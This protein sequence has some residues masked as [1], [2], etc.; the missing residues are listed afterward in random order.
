MRRVIVMC[1]KFDHNVL[2]TTWYTSQSNEE[3]LRVEMEYT[4]VTIQKE[5]TEGE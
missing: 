1:D 2:C 4:T 5:E 3:R